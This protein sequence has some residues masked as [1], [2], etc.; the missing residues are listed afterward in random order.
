MS[1]SRSWEQYCDTTSKSYTELYGWEDV[2]SLSKGRAAAILDAAKRSGLAGKSK[3]N[4]GLTK[5]QVYEVLRG[6]LSSLGGRI[7]HI[8]SRN[9]VR[10]FLPQAKRLANDA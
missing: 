6:G 10:E 7:A 4:P 5:V 3:I 9:I 2:P 8:T 1:R